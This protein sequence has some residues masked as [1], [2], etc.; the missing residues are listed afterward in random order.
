MATS[1][2]DSICKELFWEI[3]IMEIYTLLKVFHSISIVKHFE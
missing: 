3:Y 1:K 2:W